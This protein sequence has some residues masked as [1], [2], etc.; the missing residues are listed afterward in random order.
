MNGDVLTANHGYPVRVIVPGVAGARSVEWLD[1]ITVQE[2]ESSNY[3]QQ[4]DYKILPPEAVDQQT[5]EKYWDETPALQ[6]MP[7]NS[8][9]E[10]PSSGEGISLP[11]NG[12]IDVRGYAV[13][14]GD[15]ESVTK[16]ETSVDGGKT[17]E[18]ADIVGGIEGRGKWC[19][20]LW[21][22][23]VKLEKGEKKSILSRAEDAGGNIQGQIAEWNLRGVAYNGYGEA[24]DLSIL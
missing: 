22:T 2:Q 12:S 13:P 20:V 24:R 4:H 18:E 15:S 9:I 7:I 23:P 5:A 10:T 21:R 16:V 1:R 19:W 6:E 11:G 14:Q 8:I 17:W 3:Y